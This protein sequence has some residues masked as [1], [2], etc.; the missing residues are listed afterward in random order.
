MK[1]NCFKDTNNLTNMVVQRL[2]AVFC[3]IFI[4]SCEVKDQTNIYKTPKV[5]YELIENTI[6]IDK[7]DRQIFKTFPLASIDRKII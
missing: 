7:N 4:S 2:M 6:K 3:I 5:K 1:I